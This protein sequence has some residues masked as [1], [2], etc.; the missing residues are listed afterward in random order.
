MTTIPTTAHLL[1]QH[2]DV[3]LFVFV[4]FV[5]SF[6]RLFVRYVCWGSAA[7]RDDAPRG[8]FVDGFPSV[9][10]AGVRLRLGAF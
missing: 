6:V 4:S 5:R 1:N 7:A 8:F 10:V 3:H 2:S 9:D